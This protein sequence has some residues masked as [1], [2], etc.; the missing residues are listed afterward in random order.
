MPLKLPERPH[1]RDLAPARND[2]LAV[3][4]ANPVLEI[5]AA[6]VAQ[7]PLAWVQLLISAAKS[8]KAL[9][10]EITILNPSFAFLFA[11]EALGLKPESDLFT[12][13]YTP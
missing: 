12:L 2:M 7:L 5:D 6:D 9:H 13:E 8:A 11:F 4:A 3:L 1:P 10:R